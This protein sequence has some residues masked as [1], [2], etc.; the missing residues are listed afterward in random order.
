VYA[1]WFSTTRFLVPRGPREVATA[2][3]MRRLAA[4]SRLRAVAR[5]RLLSTSTTIGAA[6]A[7]PPE[8]VDTVVVGGG[9]VGACA[10]WRLAESGHSV[11]V[12]EQNTLTSGTTWHAAGLVSTVKGHEAMVSMVKYTRDLYIDSVD[13]ATGLSPVGWAQTGSLGLARTPD[14]W[15]Q[16]Q[17]ATALLEEYGVRHTL[18]GPGAALPLSAAQ[19][20]HP[21]LDL[22]GDGVLGA[23]HT[24]DDGIVNPSDACMH[25]IRLA[26][27]A[28]VRFIEHCGVAELETQTL[29]DGALTVS[30]V[31]TV[32]GDRVACDNAL[33]ACGQWTRQL[34]ASV[35][36][37]V[38]V[39]IVPHQY[40]VFDRM[41]DGNGEAMVDNTLP[42]VRDYEQKVYVRFS[43]SLALLPPLLSLSPSLQVSKSPSHQVSLSPCLQASTPKLSLLPGGCFSAG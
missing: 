2:A 1:S 22:E 34:A 13:E 5:R 10:A 11:V 39:A 40:T 38:P 29:P 23:L 9:I 4:A 6:A 30:G 14:M 27:D 19:G 20:I 15:V 18:Y 25:F 3:P 7:P 37:N 21:L 17:R 33:L 31:V 41:L 8:R 26:R 28:G 42:V 35:G 43:L 32:H 12:L 36:V 16:L 24:P